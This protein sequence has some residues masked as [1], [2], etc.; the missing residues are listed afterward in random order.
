MIKC[1]HKCP[2]R[3]MLIHKDGRVTRCHSWCKTYALQSLRHE[4]LLV[5]ERVRS[6]IHADRKE[7]IRQ[8]AEKIRRRH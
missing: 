5:A 1:C 3:W 7:R 8:T 6:G 4:S 2:K